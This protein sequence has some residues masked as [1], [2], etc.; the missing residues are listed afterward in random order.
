MEFNSV[1]KREQSFPNF[2]FFFYFTFTSDKQ[3]EELDT[4]GQIDRCSQARNWN[5]SQFTWSAI[6][7]NAYQ[8]KHLI[9]ISR[10]ANTTGCE[11]N[12]VEDL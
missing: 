11:R 4:K 8:P 6:L 9:N 10:I 3:R 7:L 12:A 1:S 5:E 2:L